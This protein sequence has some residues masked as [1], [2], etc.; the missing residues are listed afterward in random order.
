MLSWKIS[1][2][3]VTLTNFCVIS[4]QECRK[5]ILGFMA[6]KLMPVWLAT[7]MFKTGL[8]H[9]MTNFFKFSKRTVSEVL[10]ELTSNKDLQT[11]LAYNFG[12]YGMSLIFID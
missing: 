7:I 3:L 5:S 10:S 11:V 12:D 4:G 2:Y 1:K 6:F 9:W 8:V